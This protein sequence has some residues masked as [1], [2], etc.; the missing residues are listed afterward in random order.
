MR[1]TFKTSL[2]F[3]LIGLAISAFALTANGQTPGARASTYEPQKPPAPEKPKAQKNIRRASTRPARV[4]MV[5]DQEPVA[6][7]IVTVVHRLS[8][9]KL[10]RYLLRENGE[11]GTIATINPDAIANDAHA[12]IIAGL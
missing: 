2:V 5:K 4:T 12:S 6:P 7:Q 11:P 1:S 3:I 9:V 8:G 10:L